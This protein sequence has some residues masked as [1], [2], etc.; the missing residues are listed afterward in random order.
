MG[1]FGFGSKKEQ[2]ASENDSFSLSGPSNTNLT[3][4]IMTAGIRGVAIETNQAAAQTITLTHG[5]TTVVGENAIA[6]YLDIRGQGAPLR[7]KK[8]RHL[9]DQN[10]WIEVSSQ[11]LDADNKVE[12]VLARMDEILAKQEFLAEVLTL[13]DSFVAASVLAIKKRGS[14]P[15]G[16]TNI[17][18]WLQHVEQKIPENI[19]AD[20]MSQVNSEEIT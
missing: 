13:A 8:A 18:A 4:C 10:R 15:S 16:L 20:I 19:R 17:E 5:P 3:K 2:A 14:L 1:L 9:G 7:P 12:Q 6:A 11:F